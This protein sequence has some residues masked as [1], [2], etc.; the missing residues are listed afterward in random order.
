MIYPWIQFVILAAYLWTINW[1]FYKIWS[2]AQ[3]QHI[4]I[5]KYKY[6]ERSIDTANIQMNIHR[7]IWALPFSEL[8][9]FKH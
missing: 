7:I 4:L 2:R 3:Y 5:F 6:K 8:S 1:A 9:F